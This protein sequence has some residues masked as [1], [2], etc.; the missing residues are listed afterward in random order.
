MWFYPHSFD[1]KHS[2][3]MK[4][5]KGELKLEFSGQR[6]ICPGTLLTKKWRWWRV[7]TT[8]MDNQRFFWFY[9][10]LA[11]KPK[12]LSAR[13][14]RDQRIPTLLC[15]HV[16]SATLNQNI[17]CLGS[18]NIFQK[19]KN[20]GYCCVIGRNWFARSN[21]PCAENAIKTYLWYKHEK[22]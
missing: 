19:A 11:A 14:I 15:R 6:P 2:S 10:N 18:L 4:V 7:E 8:H 16:L 1:M 20:L 3:D 21:I 5:M 17:W 12:S 9:I 22:R 13:K